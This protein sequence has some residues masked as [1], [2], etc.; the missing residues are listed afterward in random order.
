MNTTVLMRSNDLVL[1]RPYDLFNFTMMTF[2]VLTLLNATRPK[3]N[4]YDI[5]SL[6]LHTISAHVYKKDFDMVN[7]IL[8][9]RM[10]Y[11]DTSPTTTR[12]NYDWKHIVN[13][14]LACRDSLDKLPGVWEIRP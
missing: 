10:N 1:G 3:L 6:T 14:L 5:G 11:L 2:K 12:M 13:S 8:S 4:W 7:E 9:N